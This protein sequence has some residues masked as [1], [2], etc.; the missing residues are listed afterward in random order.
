[1]FL[2]WSVCG[3]SVTTV[4]VSARAVVSCDKRHSGLWLGRGTHQNYN[5]NKTPVLL[6]FRIPLF[7]L[8]L[9]FKTR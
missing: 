1:M 3:G 9:V 5:S 7:V 4:G 8:I 6:V 2:E